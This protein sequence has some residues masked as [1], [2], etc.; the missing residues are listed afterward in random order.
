MTIAIERRPLLPGDKLPNGAIVLCLRGEIILALN[1]GNWQ[2]WV[3]WRIDADH[4]AY[5]GH[6]F[7][8]LE[9]AISDFNARSA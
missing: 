1:P 3:T 8:S 7:G 5:L 9:E 4:N 6:Y 2:P